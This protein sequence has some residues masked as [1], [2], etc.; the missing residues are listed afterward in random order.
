MKVAVVAFF[1]RA[2]W[3]SGFWGSA[4]RYRRIG[5]ASGIPDSA[6]GQGRPVEIW[7]GAH[8]FGPGDGPSGP[9]PAARATQ[10]DV[11]CL[12]HSVARVGVG[13]EA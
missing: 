8:Q 9:A 3:V 12:L 10:L 13:P 1:E 7:D 6:A 4:V 5:T 11:T 2:F